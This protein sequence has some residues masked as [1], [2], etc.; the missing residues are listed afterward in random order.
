MRA[1]FVETN[2]APIKWALSRKNL[3]AGVLR[4]PLVSVRPESE[5]II[6]GAMRQSGLL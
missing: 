2:P 1:A 3:P 4:L 5:T 6:E